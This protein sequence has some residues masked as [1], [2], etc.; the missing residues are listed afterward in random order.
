VDARFGKLRESQFLR[1]RRTPQSH[2][3]V[4]AVELAFEE[5]SFAV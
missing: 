3:N 4:H 2:L 1:T 5:Y